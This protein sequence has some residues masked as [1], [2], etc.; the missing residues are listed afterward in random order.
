MF[1]LH[2]LIFILVLYF[3]F[4]FL[5]LHLDLPSFIVIMFSPLQKNYSTEIENNQ[6]EKKSE[7][8]KSTCPCSSIYSHNTLV[9]G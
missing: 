3:F 1:S 4:H 9:S 6:K 8:R 5:L 2:S 7:A